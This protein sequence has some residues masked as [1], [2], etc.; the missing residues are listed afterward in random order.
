MSDLWPPV[1]KQI[2][3]NG[4]LLHLSTNAL[5]QSHETRYVVSSIRSWINVDFGFGVDQS[6]LV[7]VWGGA[8]S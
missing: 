3:N 1:T 7:L 4:R 8:L 5:H 6:V 2:R